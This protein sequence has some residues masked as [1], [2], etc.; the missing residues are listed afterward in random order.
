[1]PPYREMPGQG[2]GSGL[3]SRGRGDRKL[4]FRVETKKGDNILKV[5]KKI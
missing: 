2:S 3:M 5:N 1:M 4:G